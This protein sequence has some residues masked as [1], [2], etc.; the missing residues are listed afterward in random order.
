MVLESSG[1]SYK[2]DT[3]DQRIINDVISGK[4]RIIDVQGGFIH[5]TTYDKTSNAWPALKTA[6]AP[7]DKDKDGIPDSW[8]NAKKLN[9]A[10]PG[11]AIKNS[12]HS[13]YTNIEIYLNELAASSSNK[14]T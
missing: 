4:G 12:L 8:E 13:H 6:E 10:D 1:A 3:L 5:G 2:R 9:P 7:V 14:K 11:D